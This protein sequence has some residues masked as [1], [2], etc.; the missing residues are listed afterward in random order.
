MQ[1]KGLR[2]GLPNHSLQ[3][4]PSNSSVAETDGPVNPGG[5]TTS[6]SIDKI[7]GKL[8]ASVLLNEGPSKSDHDA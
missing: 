4:S 2:H 8:R 1:L 7:R 5:R 3:F 6:A